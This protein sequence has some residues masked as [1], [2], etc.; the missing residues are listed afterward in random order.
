MG[1]RDADRDAD[2]DDGAAADAVE[3][4]GADT[5]ETF[6]TDRQAEVLSLRAAGATQ[7]EIAER[8]GSTVANVSAIERAARDNVAR[9]ERTLTLAR[10]LHSVARFRVA[11]GTDL[12]EV[13]DRVFEAGDREGIRVAYSDPAL[14]TRLQ[15]HLDPWLEERRLTEAVSVGVTADGEVVTHPSAVPGVDPEEG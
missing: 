13:V 4:E 15:A 8:F 9:A 10:L 6:L 1:D 5:A 2:A 12:R 11:A 14:A 3:G 7:R